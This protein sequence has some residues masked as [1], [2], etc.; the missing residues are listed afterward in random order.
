MNSS[1]KLGSF[2]WKFTPERSMAL[3]GL[4]LLLIVAATYDQY[5]FSG[6]EDRGFR[7][8]THVWE[9]L[10]GAGKTVPSTI[11][12]FHGAAPD[13]LA[14]FA[15][16][17]APSLSFDSR[18]LVDALFGVAGIFFVYGFGREFVGGWTGF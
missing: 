12:M 10:S 8:A 3:L 17:L 7:R 16:K 9:F 1:Q 4:A 6:D 2:D 5:G 15:Q 13:A 18:H 14:L 11:D